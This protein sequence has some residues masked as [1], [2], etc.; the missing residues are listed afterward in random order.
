MCLQLPQKLIRD[1]SVSL[2]LIL[3]ALRLIATS[4]KSKHSAG[5]MGLAGYVCF[6]TALSVAAAL[7]YTPTRRFLES[8]H[9]PRYFVIRRVDYLHYRIE[10]VH[11]LLRFV[12]SCTSVRIMRGAEAFAGLVSL[13]GA[14]T[15]LNVCMELGLRIT[16]QRQMRLRAYSRLP[17]VL[18]VLLQAFFEGGMRQRGCA[19]DSAPTCPNAIAAPHKTRKTQAFTLAR[20]LRLRCI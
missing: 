10:R 16:G 9:C 18:A 8:V 5:N 15:V 19:F 1:R 17:S 2:R 11:Y 20:S 4:G 12:A 6:M 7:M 13:V 14:A 3:A